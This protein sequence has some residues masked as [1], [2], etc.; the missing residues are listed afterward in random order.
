MTFHNEPETFKTATGEIMGVVVNRR[1]RKG[2]EK[3]Q[4]LTLPVD[5]RT[6]TLTRKGEVWK[7]S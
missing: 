2:P 4:I 1:T 5:G 7:V 3:V 6:L